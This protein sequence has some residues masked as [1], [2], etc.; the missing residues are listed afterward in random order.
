MKPFLTIIAL[1][2]LFT[3]DISAQTHYVLDGLTV[4]YCNHGPQ[5]YT[6]DTDAELVNTTWTIE[7][8]GGSFILSSNNY[9]A[10]I[11]F[12]APGTYILLSTSFTADNQVLSDSLFIIV[13][14]EIDMPEIIGCYEG[15]GPN[16]ECYDV[17]AH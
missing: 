12:G 15:G 13:E 4:I 2:W 14:G 1:F 5:R 17:C 8:A 16:D 3:T 7:P 6:I 11:S 9:T 10:T